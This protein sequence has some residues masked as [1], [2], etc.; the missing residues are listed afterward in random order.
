MSEKN[1]LQ[2][3]INL[4]TQGRRKEAAVELLNLENKITEKNLRIQ[5]IDASLSALDPINENEKLIEMS[6]E[7][8][9]IV[10]DYNKRDIQAYFMS[11]RADFLT[12][13][14]TFLQYRQQN[15]KLAPGWIEFS[16]EADKQEYQKLTAQVDK[17]EREVDDLL[18]Q[19]LSLA[20]Q[21]GSK[22]I[23]GR[24]LMAKGSVESL[25][26][27]H[28]KTECIRGGLRAKLWLKFNFLRYPFFERL[29]IYTGKNAQK[30][31]SFVD[32]FTEK[33]LKAAQ[34][35]EES[36]DSMAGYAYHNLANNFST[37]YRFR[38]AKKYLKKAKNIAIK[39]NDSLLKRQIEILEKVIKA[40]NKN[41]PDY[42]NGETRES[43]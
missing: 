8:I 28:Y 1:N 14:V 32:T 42:L 38:K 21:S 22:N 19:A 7:G 29:I 20:E 31:Q 39:H 40:K 33:F 9:K 37:A 35:F 25:R 24:V 5:L 2:N 36:G 3:A 17:L 43:D 26:Y 16:I 6:G 4:L 27:F 12:I 10:G 23:F 34:I 13:K 15:L 18:T 30:L 41:V 11:R